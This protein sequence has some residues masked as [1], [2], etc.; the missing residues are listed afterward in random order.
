MHFSSDRGKYQL[1]LR[2]NAGF[3]WADSPREGL[4][5]KAGR[6]ERELKRSGGDAG[7]GELPVVV[8]EYVEAG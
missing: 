3:P 5:R 4:R 1:D 6:G 7:K 2:N 8:G